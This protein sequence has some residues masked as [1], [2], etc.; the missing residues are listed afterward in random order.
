MEHVSNSGVASWDV[1]AVLSTRRVPGTAGGVLGRGVLETP[2]G[3]P[4]TSRA[5]DTGRV[6]SAR[7]PW[8]PETPWQPS[9]RGTTPDGWFSHLLCRGHLTR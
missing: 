7:R 2:A 9:C 8:R 3:V 4:R 6:P 5:Q 1:A